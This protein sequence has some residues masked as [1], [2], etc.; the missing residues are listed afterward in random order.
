[1]IDRDAGVR[2]TSGDRHHTRSGRRKRCQSRGS[3]EPCYASVSNDGRG[4][5][6]ELIQVNSVGRDIAFQIAK[7]KAFVDSVISTK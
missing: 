4:S 5:K 6:G 3:C 2:A 7:A 1:M